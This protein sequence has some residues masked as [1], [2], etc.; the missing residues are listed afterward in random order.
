[1]EHD[2]LQKNRKPKRHNAA[3]DRRASVRLDSG[4]DL[5]PFVTGEGR[6]SLSGE[7]LIQCFS[8]V[9]E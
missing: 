4:R 6:R 1:M 2:L 9:D 5:F 8:D 7:G 3:T